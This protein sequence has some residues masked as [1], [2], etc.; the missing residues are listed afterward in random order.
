M[1]N[2]LDQRIGTLAQ[3]LHESRHLV[4]FT[5][6][7]ISTES[8]LPDF[9]GPDGVWTRRDKGLPPKSMT[10][11]WDSV[12]PNSGHLA[13]VEL[14]KLGKLKFLISQNVDNLHLKSGIHPDLLA[15]LHG[16]MTKLRCKKCSKVVDRS[17]HSTRCSCSGEL[18]SSVVNFGEPLPARDLKL[19]FEHSQKSDLFTVVGSSLVVTPAADMPKEA[20]LSG[21]KL[22]IINRGETPYDPFANLRFHEKIGDVLPGA[23]K[24]LKKLM[25]LFE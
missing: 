16:N 9:R 20:L 1:N 15:E 25:G 8:G 13:I 10:R 4:V 5:G 11:S 23:V 18:V 2:D 12:E 17:D 7:G 14:Q 24:R 3:W 22:V 19:S 6:A 21:A